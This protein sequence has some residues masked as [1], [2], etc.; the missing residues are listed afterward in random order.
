MVQSNL[1]AKGRFKEQFQGYG[2]EGGLWGDWQ[3]GYGFSVIGHIGGSVLY[4]KTKIHERITQLP[5]D[6]QSVSEENSVHER[7]RIYSGTPTIDYFIGLQYVDCIC[8]M[9]VSAK[10]GWEQQILFNANQF[11]TTGNLATQGLTLG[12]DVAF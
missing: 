3:I 9:H 8:D 1:L 11:A 6:S 2:A 12:L 5:I 7:S 4:T 10:A